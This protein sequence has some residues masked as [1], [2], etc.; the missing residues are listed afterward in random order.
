MILSV[1]DVEVAFPAGL[2]FSRRSIRAV[3]GVSFEIGA[4]ETF[5]LVGESGSGKTT[6]ARAINGLQSIAGGEVRFDGRRI[7][8]LSR[9]ASIPLRRQ[10]ALM[11][12]DPLGSLSPRMKVGD[13]VAEPFRVHGLKV[14][15]REETMRLLSLVGLSADFAA[16]Y[17]HQ[18]SGG[19]ARRVGV[20]RAIALNPRLIIA[21]EPTAGLDVSVQGE[22]LNLLNDLRERLGLAMLIITHNLPVVK[23]V[24][25]RMAVMYLGRIVESG[26]TR[27]LFRAPA[28]PYTAALLS[29]SPQP[30]PAQARERISLPAEVPSL[31]ERPS[32]CEFHTR[33]PWSKPRCATDAPDAIYTDDAGGARRVLCHYP[34]ASNATVATA[35][36]GD[37]S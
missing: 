18:L 12:Q 17:P 22:V 25:D 34:L 36:T 33:C 3:A 27:D 15:L 9:A 1:R 11:F 10:M 23:H 6:L 24:A 20:A 28:H 8:R 19:Q 30:H 26:D 21:D 16:R 13:S 7:D 35:T 29:A 14:N 31:L 4:G 5:A 2:W 37:T 32:G